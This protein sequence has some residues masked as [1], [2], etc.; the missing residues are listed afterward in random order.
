MA[1][2]RLGKAM[3]V[4]LV[5]SSALPRSKPCGGA[6]NPYS[7]KFLQQFGPPR[8]LF[9][10]PEEVRFRWVDFD[11]KL[12][13]V[14]GLEFKNVS[15]EAFD[16]WLLSLI[17]DTVEVRDKTRFLGYESNCHLTKVRLE[18]P[19]G[20]LTVSTRYVIGADGAL[21]QVRRRMLGGDFATYACIQDWVERPASMP[22]Y[23]DC[24]R[25][26]GI[27]DGHAYTYAVPKGEAALV[28]SVFYPGATAQKAK[29]GQVMEMLRDRLG[30]GPT[31]KRESAAALQVR[32]GRDVIFGDGKVL[33]TGEAAGFISP[34]SG[35]GISYALAT[36]DL[37][38]QAILA[39]P[40][41][42]LEK[43]RDMAAG[44]A[45]NITRKA[46][47]LALLEYRAGHAVL[48]AMPLGILS[49]MT[50]RL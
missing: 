12:N 17:P 9:L 44:P 24:I 7:W 45:R 16:E 20:G 21:S 39:E 40:D 35:E 30:L 49:W 46:R 5:D 10:D 1:A 34:T 29:H 18:T 11:S 3:R 13:R 27:G 48:A 8:H 33:L 43:Y 41:R 38:A 14:T 32:S 31:T 26:K 47:K 28:G 42:S 19:T 25:I 4:L 2:R 37:C 15:R 23:F 50:K 22:P 6:L 36:G